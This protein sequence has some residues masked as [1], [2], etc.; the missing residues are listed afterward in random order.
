V[1]PPRDRPNADGGGPLALAGRRARHAGTLAGPRHACLRRLPAPSDGNKHCPGQPTLA[2]RRSSTEAAAG[3][4]SRARWLAAYED[5]RRRHLAGETL[6]AIGRITGLAW[7]TVR[8]HAHA[9][10]FP[11]RAV[12][13][14][15]RSILDPFIAYLEARM[16]EGCEDATALW[17]EVQG[18]G[19][20]H[21]PKVVQKWVAENRAKP[22]L[23]TPRKWLQGAPAGA[24]PG[25]AFGPGPALP[26]PRQ[27]AWLLARPTTAL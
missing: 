5:V 7:A 9:E 22:A 12:R 21:G 4:D 6:L 11:G 2:F 17:R 26:S 1:L 18:Q 16:A 14:P 8:K 27:L 3:A 23:M 20:A 15:G 13:R 24:A 19:Y 10:S 25:T